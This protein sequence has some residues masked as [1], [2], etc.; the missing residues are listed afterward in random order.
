METCSEPSRVRRS[1]IAA[2]S[3]SGV[4]CGGRAQCLSSSTGEDMV[5]S[6]VGTDDL[7]L[8]VI[9]IYNWMVVKAGIEWISRRSCS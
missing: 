9:Y 2:Q 7:L 3:D 4:W 5:V 1:L 8:G 6:A